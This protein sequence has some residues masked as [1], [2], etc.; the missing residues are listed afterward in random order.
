MLNKIPNA[1][2]VVTK[3]EPPELINGSALPANGNKP[4]ITAILIN[5]SIPIQ[6]T[7]PDASNVPSISGARRAITSPRQTNKPYKPINITAPN[8]PNSSTTTAKIL[9]VGGTGNPVTFDN[10]LPMPTPNQP[11]LTMASNE[12]RT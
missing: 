7:K 9:S 1:A 6:I 3:F 4:T 8:Q 5:A 2:R 11:P 10:E 12:R